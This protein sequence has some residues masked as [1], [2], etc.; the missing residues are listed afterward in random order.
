MIRLPILAS[1]TALASGL[2]FTA[3]QAETKSSDYRFELTGK[4]QL[5]AKKDIVQVRLVRVADGK[6]IPDAVVFE[7]KADMGP[8]GMETMTAPVKALPAKGGVYSFEIDP[9]MAGTWALHLAAKVQGEPETIRG[10]VNAD[11]VK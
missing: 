1:A 11:L 8:S 5:S 3:V 10:T 9:A 4:P 2:V 6:P 7:S